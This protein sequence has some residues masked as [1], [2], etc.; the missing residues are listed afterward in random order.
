[1]LTLLL[2]PSFFS[3]AISLEARL[4]RFFHRV[5]G[6]DAHRDGQPVPAE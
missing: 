5:V 2:V 6:E 3:I 1:L 4:G